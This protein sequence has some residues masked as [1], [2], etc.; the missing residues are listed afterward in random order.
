MR[1][2]H[3]SPRS[4]PASPF[5]SLCRLAELGYE[6]SDCALAR[7]CQPRGEYEIDG[8]GLRPPPGRLV[9]LGGE[10]LSS[11][12]RANRHKTPSIAS[13]FGNHD[14]VSGEREPRPAHVYDTRAFTGTLSTSM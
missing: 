2:A 9:E 1:F 14:C 10:A 12:V 7:G 13:A 8:L 6:R 11:G 5:T 4:S 3:T